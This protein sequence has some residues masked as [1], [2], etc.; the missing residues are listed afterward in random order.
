M[1]YI[2]KDFLGDPMNGIIKYMREND[3]LQY[4]SIG[5]SSNYWGSVQNILLQDQNTQYATQSWIGEYIEVSFPYHYIEINGYGLLPTYY[6]DN[7]ISKWNVMCFEIEG[8]KEE[9]YVISTINM[10][11]NICGKNRCVD[12]GT[13]IPQ[14]FQTNTTR[15]CN[16]LRFVITGADTCDAYYF[17][18]SGIEF[19]GTLGS[20]IHVDKCT[21]LYHFTHFLIQHF[22]SIFLVFMVKS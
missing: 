8:A 22:I 9:Q 16:K 15:K 1:S 2:R 11:T 3:L 12:S 14:Y 7:S 10:D 13:T 19:F 5:E 17:V 6:D 20:L 21:F 18:I 4:I